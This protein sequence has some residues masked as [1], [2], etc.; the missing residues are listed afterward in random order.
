MAKGKKKADLSVSYEPIL[1]AIETA[2]ATLKQGIVGADPVQ[3]Q[4]IVTAIRN[5]DVARVVLECTQSLNATDYNVEPWLHMS[6]V[7]AVRRFTARRRSG[8]R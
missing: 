7:A 8:D 6:D 4:R 2:R 1:Q 5:L 3:Q